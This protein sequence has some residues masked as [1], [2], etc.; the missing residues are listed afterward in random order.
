MRIYSSYMKR[1][2]V[3]I[4][5]SHEEQALLARELSLRPGFFALELP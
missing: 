2:D 3:A 4:V 1:E 5:L